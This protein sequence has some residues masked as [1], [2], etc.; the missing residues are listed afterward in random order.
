MGKVNITLTNGTLGGVAATNDGVAGLVCTGTG[1]GVT[2]NTPLTVYSLDDAIAQ[3]ITEADEPFAYKHI[4][5]FYS[6]APEGSE[7]WVMTVADTVLLANMTTL[8]YANGIKK[9][10]DASGQRIALAAC[11]RNPPEDYTPSGAAQF[12][13]SDSIA[14]VSPA[15][16][17]VVA[18]QEKY[19]PLRVLIEGRVVAVAN[20]TIYAPNTAAANG[21]AMVIGGSES[22]PGASVGLALGRAAKNAVQRNIGAVEDGPVGLTG[23]AY[24]GTKTVDELFNSGQLDTL[25]DAGYMMLFKYAQ[26]AGYYWNDDHMLAPDSD[27]YHSLANGRVIDKAIKLTY[28]TYI[29][30]I[31]TDILIDAAGKIDAGVAK[32]LEGKIE[33]AVNTAM[34]GEISA[35]DAFIDVNQ[36]VLSTEEVAVVLKIT[37]KGYLKS[38]DV[39]LGF[40]NPF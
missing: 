10:V 22:G 39:K 32:S 34:A 35:F 23:T 12:L 33:N 31:N 4:S 25:E 29:N 38:I 30:S 16:L 18:Y 9:L 3:G 7:L 20:V 14:A 40:D 5:E 2:V 1:D 17:L 28:A 6:E 24:I 11:A 8:A 15:Q 27:D 26:K 13:D 37:P 21:A 36:N 19:T